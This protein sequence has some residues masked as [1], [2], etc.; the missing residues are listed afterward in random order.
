M[1]WYLL[2]AAASA[3]ATYLTLE[4]GERAADLRGKVLV[5][6][7]LRRGVP[8]SVWRHV[9]NGKVC[10]DVSAQHA[11]A[12]GR[13]APSYAGEW[14]FAKRNTSDPGVPGLLMPWDPR[15]RATAQAPPSSKP[16][17]K[18]DPTGPTAGGLVWGV[19]GYPGGAKGGTIGLSETTAATGRV[20]SEKVAAQEGG[21]VDDPGDSASSLPA[22]VFGLVNAWPPA[23]AESQYHRR[24]WIYAHRAWVGNHPE[25][26]IWALGIILGKRHPGL[27]DLWQKL[28]CHNADHGWTFR[29]KGGLKTRVPRVT[30]AELAWSYAYSCA[31]A[32]CLGYLERPETIAPADHLDVDPPLDPPGLQATE[33]PGG[34]WGTVGMSKVAVDVLGPGAAMWAGAGGGFKRGPAVAA[35]IGLMLGMG[36]QAHRLL[37]GAY[38]PRGAE[39]L[40]L[41]SWEPVALP[42]TEV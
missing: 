20:L 31:V 9:V 27:A 2:A 26:Y 35:G 7:G 8:Q 37:S 22:A 29:Q 10:L 42:M 25:P 13:P 1:L 3:V 15:H 30:D 14:S 34:P 41:P 24:A 38:G 19:K 4:S 36:A 6:R 21:G 40:L 16:E 5:P 32:A 23:A 33:S 39:K 11:Y 18:Y 28:G 12:T 17:V